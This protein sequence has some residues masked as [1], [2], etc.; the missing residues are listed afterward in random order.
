MSSKTKGPSLTFLAATSVFGVESF[1]V[2]QGGCKE[3]I[4]CYFIREAA[5]RFLKKYPELNPA[6][7]LLIYDNA[8]CHVN[9]FSGWWCRQMP[10]I[11]MT[12]APYS[13]EY[14]ICRS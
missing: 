9:S 4:W 10:G 2:I 6:D 11:K 5:M 12:I 3:L 7:L 8:S 14:L 13:P 1:I